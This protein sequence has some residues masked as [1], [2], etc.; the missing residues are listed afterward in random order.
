M[1]VKPY[2]V[3]KEINGKD[4]VAQFNGLSVAMRAADS[5]HIGESNNISTEKMAQ[6]LFDNVIVEPKGLTIDD[7]ESM[8]ELTE[9]TSFASGVMNGSFREEVKQ[10]KAEKESKE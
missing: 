3:K 8:E 9:V 1:A 10:S 2:T 6:Y 4:Y 7:F 5:C